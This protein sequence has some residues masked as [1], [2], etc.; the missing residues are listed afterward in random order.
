MHDLGKI[1]ISNADIKIMI[2]LPGKKYR[3]D[4]FGKK[5]FPEPGAEIAS[6]L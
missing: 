5:K 6:L 1:R 2:D 3:I 4:R